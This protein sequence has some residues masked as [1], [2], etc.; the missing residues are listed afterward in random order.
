MTAL[1][2]LPRI[3]PA[4]AQL[5]T[6]LLGALNGIEVQGTLLTAT[7]G[8]EPP[9]LSWFA[10]QGGPAFAI[11]RLAGEPVRLGPADGV[12]AAEC[13]ELAEPVLQA[14]EWAL[15][16][17]LEPESL[18][19][20]MPGGDPLWLHVD[21]RAGIATRDRI[22]LA[23][24]RS[25]NLIATAAPLAPRLLD[26]VPFPAQVTL[27]GPRLSPIDAAELAAGDLLLLGETPLSATIRFLDRPP[28]AGFYEPTAR[29]FTPLDTQE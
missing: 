5:R 2:G 17:E 29:R 3:E 7:I 15:H 11:E 8:A 23:I 26:E 25:L 28:V 13:L 19:E 21:A 18:G 1:T 12:R 27:T 20:A 4:E 6:D 16:L 22:V 14:I 24:P 9:R 10:C